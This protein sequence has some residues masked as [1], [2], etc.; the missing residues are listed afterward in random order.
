MFSQTAEY[1][2][3]TVVHLT[4]QSPLAQ[5]IDQIATTT[6]VPKAYLSKVVQGLCRAHIVTARRG[7]GGGIV[8]AKPPGELTILDVVNAVE[9][10]VRIQQ[11]P[12]GLKTHGEHLCPLHR[13]MDETLAM[14]EKTFQQTTLAEIVAE[15][16]HSRPLCETP[17]DKPTP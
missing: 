12:L 11:C 9:P 5:T 10:I 14:I 8:L 16:T 13:Q 7:V 15:P 17:A 4:D 6:H 2:L 3:R 1:A